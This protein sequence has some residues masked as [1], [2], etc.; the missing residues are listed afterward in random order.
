MRD[1]AHLHDTI[2]YVEGNPVE[3]K[4]VNGASRRPIGACNGQNR[5]RDAGGPRGATPPPRS[6]HPQRSSRSASR[7]ARAQR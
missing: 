7:K 4:L 6:K 1:Q 2:A 3:A 5:R